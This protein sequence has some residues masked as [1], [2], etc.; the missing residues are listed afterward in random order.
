M[1]TFVYA[2]ELVDTLDRGTCLMVA[3][4]QFGPVV[5]ADGY[6]QAYRWLL[7][8][9][10]QKRGKLACAQATVMMGFMPVRVR[11]FAITGRERWRGGD[12]RL[13]ML[14]GRRSTNNSTEQLLP[15]R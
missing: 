3:K 2:S 12:T 10:L 9:D 1:L 11:M 4:Q 7:D 15:A 14:E 5:M 6:E 8:P 13:L